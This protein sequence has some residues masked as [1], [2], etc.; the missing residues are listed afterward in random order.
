MNLGRDGFVYG[1]PPG[2]RPV[3][4]PRNPASS[5]LARFEHAANVT[6][7][8]SADIPLQSAVLDLATAPELASATVKPLALEYVESDYKSFSYPPSNM[9]QDTAN[10]MY[11]NATGKVLHVVL[12]LAG[13]LEE[14]RTMCLQS[15]GFRSN[16]SNRTPFNGL[17]F[18][19]KEKPDYDMF[20]WCDEFTERHFAAYQQMQR[21]KALAEKREA[22]RIAAEDAAAAAAAAGEGATAAAVAAND[23]GSDDE[24]AGGEGKAGD[25]GEGKAGEAEGNV[26]SDDDDDGAKSKSKKEE[27]ALVRIK[28][29]PHEPVGWFE[30]K[31]EQ[32][33]TGGQPETTSVLTSPTHCRYVTLKFLTTIRRPLCIE[34]L[35]FGGLLSSHPLS[36]V[37]GTP[38]FEPAA[39]AMLARLKR[40]AQDR[41]HWQPELDPV[42]V[43]FAQ[44]SA[45]LVLHCMYV[46]QF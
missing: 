26:D 8:V 24:G 37:V 29:S 39:M 22:A 23:D 33:S 14:D 32:F 30:I 31:Q 27:E 45:Q 44:V 11:V 15:V 21:A 43:A 38:A 25:G 2:A 1:L 17:V 42:L 7:D 20:S 5:W 28:P 16:R 36:N 6:R 4:D 35:R 3:E 19:S 18:V 13:E 41:A 12:R 10:M 34:Y 9:L 40:G 46:T